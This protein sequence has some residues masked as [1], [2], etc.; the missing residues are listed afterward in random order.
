MSDTLIVGYPTSEIT[1]VQAKEITLI[2][3]CLTKRGTGTPEDPVR[4][5]VQLWTKEGTLVCEW[6]PHADDPQ[7]GGER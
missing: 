7:R 2:V 6:D 5:I 1:G 4:I 3:T